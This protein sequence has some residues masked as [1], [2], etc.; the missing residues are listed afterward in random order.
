MPAYA[1]VEV[2]VTDPDAY[3]PYKAL[4]AEAIAKHGG[5]Y[6]VRG[7][8]VEAVEGSPPSGRVVVLQFPDMAA[9]RGWYFSEEYQ[10]ALPMRLA[11]SEGRLFFVEGVDSA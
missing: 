5:T 7:G 4:A 11:A 6:L 3:E 2:N 9:A 8:T 10:K 1:I